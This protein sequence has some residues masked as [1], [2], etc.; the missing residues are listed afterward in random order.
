[1]CHTFDFEVFH[2]QLH[3][4]FYLLLFC[5]VSLDILFSIHECV[6]GLLFEICGI[7]EIVFHASID[8]VTKL[9]G[10]KIFTL[11]TKKIV[12]EIKMH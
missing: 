3:Q 12:A 11:A 2:D 5:A 8:C 10:E 4:F 7:H 6:S 1:M 9:Q